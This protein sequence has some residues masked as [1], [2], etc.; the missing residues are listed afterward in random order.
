MGVDRVLPAA[1]GG[2]GTLRYSVSPTLPR[3]LAF[4]KSTLTL[5][6]TPTAI[7][8]STTYTYKVTDTDSGSNRPNDTATLSFTITVNSGSDNAFP[9]TRY[10]EATVGYLRIPYR[11]LITNETVWEMLDQTPVSVRVEAT[12]NWTIPSHY[13]FRL[14]VNTDQTGLQVTENNKCDF[15]PVIRNSDEWRKRN[16]FDL[17]GTSGVA[18]LIRC[19]KGSASNAGLDLVVVNTNNENYIAYKDIVNDLMM[20]PHLENDNGNL[21]H[22]VHRT[23]MPSDS[24]LREGDAY[25]TGGDFWNGILGNVRISDTTNESE[26]RIII[27][28]AFSGF[29][30]CKD[31]K[32]VACTDTKKRVDRT[33]SNGKIKKVFREPIKMFIITD[34]PGGKQWTH[35]YSEYEDKITKWIYLPHI[36]GHEFGHALGLGHHGVEHTLMYYTTSD[37]IYQRDMRPC[38][39]KAKEKDACDKHQYDIDSLRG[40]LGWTD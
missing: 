12:D 40:L 27:R 25:E 9:N 38:T 6:G 23:G 4:N 30:T 5:S 28:A 37:N 35:L 26:A 34:L 33:M 8:E 31:A 2:N 32:A 15:S 7:Q 1:S 36:V 10:L 21:K 13:S 16:E 39:D 3:G 19:G 22:Y 24:P 17:S 18:T 11:I 20:A 29:A 14:R